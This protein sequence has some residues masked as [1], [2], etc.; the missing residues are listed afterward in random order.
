MLAGDIADVVA[1]VDSR[2]ALFVASALF[3]ANGMASN[4]IKVFFFIR[5]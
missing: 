3:V 1:G 4:G 2:E 5:K